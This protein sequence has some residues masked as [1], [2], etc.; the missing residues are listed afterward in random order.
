M[1]VIKI[2]NGSG[3]KEL[4]EVFP[5]YTFQLYTIYLVS[6]IEA[7]ALYKYQMPQKENHDFHLHYGST[8][9]W[10]WVERQKHWT[11]HL[12]FWTVGKYLLTCVQNHVSWQ[13]LVR[14]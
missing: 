7:S 3:L 14:V 4:M 9:A 1:F 5:Q 11:Y 13:A 12:D 6:T 8:I 2:A 10:I